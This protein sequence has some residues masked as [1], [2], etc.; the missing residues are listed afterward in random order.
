MSATLTAIRRTDL[1]RLSL[2]TKSAA[3]LAAIVAAVAL[4]QLFH[5]VGAASGMGNAL[6]VA[7]LPMHLPVILVGLIAGPAVGAISGLLAPV[8]SFLI[9]GMPMA[10]MLPLM[11]AEL[12][13][14]G[15]AAGALR[16][17]K[18][19]SLVKVLIAQVAGRLAYTLAV[20][21]AV[22]AFGRDMSVTSIWTSSLVAGLP[23]LLL[24]WAL[25]PLAAY[26]INDQI[27][28]RG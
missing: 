4:P 1:P 26:W 9:S 21:V 3:T 28:K 15:L 14:Y 25:L 27:A 2:T 16:S 13:V 19:P 18:L 20:A 24:Q 8:A 7:F 23:G 5:V 10:A 6:G 17:V 22:F 12:A 11:M